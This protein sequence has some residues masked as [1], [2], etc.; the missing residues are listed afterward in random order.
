M[1]AI[2][3][4]THARGSSKLAGRGGTKTL[5]LTSLHIEKSWGVKSG[6]RGSQAIV[7]PRPIQPTTVQDWHDL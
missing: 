6:D 5:S 1:V 2:A 3:S 7:R 4:V